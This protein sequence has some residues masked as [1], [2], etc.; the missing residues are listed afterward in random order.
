MARSLPD[1]G[2]DRWWRRARGVSAPLNC[3][4]VVGRSTCVPDEDASGGFVIV[5]MTNSPLGGGVLPATD[6]SPSYDRTPGLWIVTAGIFALSTV[7]LSYL[8]R[9]RTR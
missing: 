3:A 2:G 5:V 7:L 4:V 9:R 1:V 6:V 8:P